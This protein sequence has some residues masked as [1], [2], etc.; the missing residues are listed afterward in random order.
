M[1]KDQSSTKRGKLNL[2]A[3]VA[4]TKDIEKMTNSAGK[5]TAECQ[6]CGASYSFNPESLGM[7]SKK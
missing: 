2:G 5:V 3:L 4:Q 6:F 7:D 1:R